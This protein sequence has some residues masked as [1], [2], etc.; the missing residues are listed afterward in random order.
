VFKL[1]CKKRITSIAI[2]A[3]LISVSAA[4][5]YTNINVSAS[6]GSGTVY[7]VGGIGPGNYS[8]IQSAINAATAGSTVFVYNGTYHEHLSIGRS[9]N[10]IGE[11]KD[12]TIVDA[13]DYSRVIYINADNVKISGFTIINTPSNYGI[14]LHMYSEHNT[15]TGNNIMNSSNGVYLFTHSS[16]NKIIDN[17]FEL[18]TFA[19]K[20]VNWAENNTVKDNV[21]RNNG[22]GIK[23]ILSDDTKI[24]DNYF[25]DNQ[26]NDISTESSKYLTIIGNKMLSDTIYGV[27]IQGVVPDDNN[28]IE[29]NVITN[30]SETGLF[31]SFVYSSIIN[32]NTITNSKHG[33]YFDRCRDNTAM[34]NTI[35]DNTHN[36]MILYSCQRHTIYNNEFDSNFWYAIN[37]PDSGYHEIYHNNFINNSKEDSFTYDQQCFDGGSSDWNS[38]SIHEGNYWNDFDEASEGAYDVDSNGIIDSPYDIPRYDR[39]KDLHPL[40]EPFVL[41]HPPVADANGPYTADEGQTMPLDGS[42]SYDPDGDALMYR[43]DLDNDGT[44]DTSYSADPTYI[45]DCIDD[46]SGTVCLEVTDGYLTNVDCTTVMVN[47]VAPTVSIDNSLDLESQCFE[48]GEDIDFIGSFTDP[49]V[50]DTHTISWDF[51]DLNSSTVSLSVTHSYM[52]PGNYVLILT[53]TDN[54]GDSG[55]AAVDICIIEITEQDEIQE[56]IEDVE[57]FELHEGIENSV[58]TKLSNAIESLNNG[59]LTE[60]K[61]ILN[62]FINHVEAQ[63][64]KKLT[65]AQ[66]DYLISEVQT[67]I[68]SI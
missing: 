65:E 19:V 42:G 9:I 20:I 1:K 53:I 22:Y 8:T 43:W 58:T 51:G 66:A 37:I 32:N 57:D 41:N 7:Y 33:I 47:N 3:I 6:N 25:A 62:A 17:M 15:I 30:N 38:T 10:L 34:G 23:L 24:L 40:A 28:I 52:Q 11:D 4:G 35:S 31:L 63:R 16:H 59:N 68:D 46:Y 44:Y 14:Y 55:L 48:V 21:M 64:G 12:T 45:Y 18:N 29:N 56:V 39:N 60:A 67:I 36:G 27:H 5:F 54:N 61:N 2:F 49:G 26:Y 13:D 50:D